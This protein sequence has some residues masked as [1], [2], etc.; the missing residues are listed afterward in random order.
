MLKIL[1][2]KVDKGRKSGC[3]CE[4]DLAKRAKQD[5]VKPWEQV[6]RVIKGIVLIL[7][8]AIFILFVYKVTQIKHENNEYDPYKI[9]ELDPVI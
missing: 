2:K 3:R 9:L 5:A 8:W 4:G 7:V 1:A 6:K